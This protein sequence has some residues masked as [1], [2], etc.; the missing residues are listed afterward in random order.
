MVLWDLILVRYAICNDHSRHQP[1]TSFRADVT[2]KT[3]IAVSHATTSTQRANKMNWD[4]V[5]GKW[6]QFKGQAQQKWGNLTSDDLDIVDG[7]REE[8]VGKLQ[9]RYGIVKED[10]EKQ[11]KEFEASCKC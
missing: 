11:V 8:L 10:A 6:K 9:E 4:Q 3:W 2:F 5:Q 7:K 1:I